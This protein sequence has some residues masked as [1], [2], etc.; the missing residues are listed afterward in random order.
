VTNPVAAGSL[1]G[2]LA[3]GFTVAGAQPSLTSVGPTPVT[4]G[5]TGNSSVTLYGDNFVL[6]ATITVG[7]LSGPTVAG[8]IASA[9]APFVFV[10]KTQ[11]KF[12]WPNTS[13]AP[14]TYAVQVANTADSGGLSSTLAGGFA[15][16]A[17]QP[18]LTNLSPAQ[19]T[20]GITNSAA[21]TVYGSNFVVGATISV[22]S[23]SGTTVAGTIATAAT[24]FVLVSSGRLSFYWPSTSLAP[25]TYSIQVMNPATA[26]ALSATL[27]SAFIVI[28]PQPSVTSLNPASVTYGV[29]NASSVTVYGSNFLVGSTVTVGSLSGTTVAGTTASTATPFVVTTNSQLKFYWPN[30][31]LLPG[32]YAVSI[33]NPSASGGLLASLADGFAVIAP[34]PAISS[35]SYPSVTYGVTTSRAITI[36]GSNFVLGG[37]ITVGSLSGTMVTG[38]T[39]TAAVPFVF[40]SSSRLS[41]YWPNTSLPVGVYSVNVV[42]P[43]A[44]GGLA[45]SLA[46][47][48]VVQ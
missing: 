13:L 23:L 8:T 14:G 25:N 36:Y 32:S 4:Y 39:A 5:I 30:T 1:A 19:V 29:S 12:Y 6:G 11:L 3:A 33:V 17:P 41:F 40:V 27:A 45:T 37:T 2:T 46:N 28:P 18:G 34:Q 35:L 10:S 47:G 38:S 24:P 42:N 16:T 9:A 21:I 15:V 22:G 26:G 31:S 44:A 48:F 7:A 43:S 20:Y